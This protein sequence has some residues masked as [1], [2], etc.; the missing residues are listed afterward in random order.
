MSTLFLN[1]SKDP[2]GATALLA[3]KSF[4]LQKIKTINMVKKSITPLGKKISLDDQFKEICDEI[5]K[6]SNLIVG[7]PVYW[8]SMSSYMK[9]FIDRL[10][11]ITSDN[12]FKGKNLY[13]VVTGADPSNT[14]P[15]IKTVWENIAKR[16]DMNL[17]ESTSN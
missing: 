10:N 3:Y 16:L 9:I 2:G 12:P 13:L 7:T 8:L 4:D 14:F 11:D 6:N 17:I 5:S 15:H 1:F